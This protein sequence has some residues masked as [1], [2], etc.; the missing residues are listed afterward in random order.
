LDAILAAHLDEGATEEALIARGFDES[1]V[2]L[3]LDRMDANAFKRAYLP[4]HPQ[5]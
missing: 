4:P 1:E 5:V 3:V 2:A